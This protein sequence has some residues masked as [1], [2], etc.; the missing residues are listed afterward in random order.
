MLPLVV[1]VNIFCTVEMHTFSAGLTCYSCKTKPYYCNAMPELH[2]V[3]NSCILFW[4][5]IPWVLWIIKLL[6]ADHSI[7]CLTATASLTIL[8]KNNSPQGVTEPVWYMLHVQYNGV[9]LQ[10]S[11]GHCLFLLSNKHIMMIY[12]HVSDSICRKPIELYRN[13]N[14]D[15]HLEVFLYLVAREKKKNVIIVLCKRVTL[16]ESVRVA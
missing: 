16:R 13:R 1:T 3:K 10:I 14:A 12:Q 11:L 8:K 2:L 4:S 5:C 6:H 15:D 7:T 9:R